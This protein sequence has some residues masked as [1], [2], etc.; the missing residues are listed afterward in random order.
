MCPNDGIP[1]IKKSH[2]DVIRYIQSLSNGTRIGICAQIR[3]DCDTP[4]ALR[5]F[6]GQK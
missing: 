1:M 5:D 4:E 6:V 3:H 2:T